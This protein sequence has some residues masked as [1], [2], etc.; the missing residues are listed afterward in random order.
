MEEEL[1]E[2]HAGDDDPNEPAD[3]EAE[4]PATQ[5]VIKFD[6]PEISQEQR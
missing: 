6:L 3:E 5:T 1:K 2:P 4:G